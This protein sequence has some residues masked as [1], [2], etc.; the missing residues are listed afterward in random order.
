MLPASETGLYQWIVALMVAYIVLAMLLNVRRHNSIHG[1][2]EIMSHVFDAATF[3]GS[4]MLL[5]GLFQPDV[6]KLLGDTKPFL[7]IAGLAGLVYAIGALFPRT[8]SA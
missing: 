4:T 1:R 6:L 7:A 5:V 2:K 3:A 8:D